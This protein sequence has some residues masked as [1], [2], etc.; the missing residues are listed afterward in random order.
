MEGLTLDTGALVALERR[1]R[2]MSLVFR[3]ACERKIRMTVPAPVLT[4]WWRGPSRIRSLIRSSVTIEPLDEPLAATAGE[5]LAAI[6]GS[7]VDAIV[8]ASAA[9]RGDIVYTSDWDDL[10]RLQQFFP[11]VRLLRAT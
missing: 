5:A 6:A 9:R 11:A 10:C 7:T 4:E 8:M 2:R 3:T 1:D